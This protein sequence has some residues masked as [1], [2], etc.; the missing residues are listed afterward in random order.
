[1]LEKSLK[2]HWAF[3]KAVSIGNLLGPVSS[4]MRANSRRARNWIAA[5]WRA[6]WSRGRVLL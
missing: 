1:M 2:A 3:R 4:R 6:A 5:C